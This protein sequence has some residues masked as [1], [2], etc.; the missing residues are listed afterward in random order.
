MCLLVVAI[1]STQ[2]TRQ[3]KTKGERNDVNRNR[4]KDK[5]D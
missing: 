2:S 1:A 5:S 4:T 3:Y